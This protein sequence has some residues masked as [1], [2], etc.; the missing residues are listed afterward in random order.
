MSD[1]RPGRRAAGEA[2]GSVEDEET[3]LA[4]WSR[5]KSTA[6]REDGPVITD[7]PADPDAIAAADE[8]GASEVAAPELTDADMPP[9]ESL[10]GESDVSGF[11]SKGVS[12]GLRRAALRKLFHS[13]KFNVCDGLDDYC[14]DFTDFAPLGAT[15]TADMRHHMERLVRENLEKAS[16]AGADT[17]AT[18]AAAGADAQPD[19]SADDPVDSGPEDDTKDDE[20]NV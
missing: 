5:L 9:V 10:D 16:P 1:K 14:E 6:N 4:R 2:A 11:L 13:P 7:N 12:E 8:R 20:N 18:M 19:P 3:F 15:I 17:G